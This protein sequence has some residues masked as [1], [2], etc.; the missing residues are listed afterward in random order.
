MNFLTVPVNLW[1]IKDWWCSNMRLQCHTGLQP[2]MLR[3]PRKVC[4]LKHVFMVR[5]P[6]FGHLGDADQ[7]A[8]LF[9]WQSNLRCG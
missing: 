5:G 8:M 9:R 2:E 3:H 7:K 1:L 4:S 6:L